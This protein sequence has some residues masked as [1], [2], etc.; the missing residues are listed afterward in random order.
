M[1]VWVCVCMCVWVYVCVCPAMQIYTVAPRASKFC[2]ASSFE[3]VQV[4]NYV[5]LGLTPHPDQNGVLEP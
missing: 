5:L 2:I 1:F 3:R 4:I